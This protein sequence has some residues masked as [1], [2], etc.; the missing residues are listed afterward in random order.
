MIFQCCYF[1]GEMGR[2]IKTYCMI[3]S[4]SPDLP[5]EKIP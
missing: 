4:D 2:E 3:L 1:L 5:T